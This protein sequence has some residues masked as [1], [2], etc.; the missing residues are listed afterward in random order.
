MRLLNEPLCVECGVKRRSFGQL[1]CLVGTHGVGAS[2]ARQVR[3]LRGANASDA[4]A[5]R[6]QL[7]APPAGTA[8]FTVRV[9]CRNCM[10]R[11]N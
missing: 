2:P 4:A 3:D 1:R 6:Y 5:V 9:M 7:I 10:G 11:C 8:V